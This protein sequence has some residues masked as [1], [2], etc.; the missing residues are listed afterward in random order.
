MFDD[1]YERREGR[2]Y[3]VSEVGTRRAKWR[4][5]SGLRGGI[6]KRKLPGQIC[7]FVLLFVVLTAGF[8]GF[9][10]WSGYSPMP[11]GLQAYSAA[12]S[13]LAPAYSTATD[14][15]T[16]SGSATKLV[17]VNYLSITTG[18]ITAAA[19]VV[20]TLNRRSA[21][22]VGGGPTALTAVK[23]DTS[24]PAATAVVNTY[25]IAK[26]VT[27]GTLLGALRSSTLFIQQGAGVLA[28]YD[29]SYHAGFMSP[30]ILLKGTSD[31]L[32]VTLPSSDPAGA[33]FDISVEWTEG[34]Q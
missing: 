8:F 14:I 6:M 9:G 22:N 20:F 33:K 11:P 32:T 18:V 28:S 16:I 2:R 26:P 23:Y 3:L 17:R 15:F 19:N 34:N 4:P 24:A 25:P 5:N 12:V 13:Q 27:L 7:F 10:Q 29:Q 1:K 30:G 21:A 31:I